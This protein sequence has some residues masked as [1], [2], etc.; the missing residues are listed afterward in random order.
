VSAKALIFTMDDELAKLVEAAVKQERM[1]PVPDAEGSGFDPR[2]SFRPMDAGTAPLPHGCHPKGALTD[3]HRATFGLYL[4]PTKSDGAPGKPQ[5]S[6]YEPKWGV[7]AP[8]RPARIDPKLLTGMPDEYIKCVCEVDKPYELLCG[9]RE[10]ATL[11]EGR[12][13]R[14]AVEA[15]F[16]A[17][18]ERML[19]IQLKYL[20][21]RNDYKLLTR[22]SINRHAACALLQKGPTSPLSTADFKVSTP[23]GNHSLIS[24]CFTEIP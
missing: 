24:V 15:M 19:V 3:V 12:L 16:I 23:G 6:E 8:V 1:F 10:P 5:A 14:E 17:F 11:A 20:E 22:D 9:H 4:V 21:I 13:V 2:H 7:W 18:I